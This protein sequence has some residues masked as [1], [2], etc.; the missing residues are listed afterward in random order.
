MI[1]FRLISWPY[2]RKH[3][4]RSLLTI[5]GIVIGHGKSVQAF[6]PGGGDQSFLIRARRPTEDAPGF[7][8]GGISNLAKQR[9]KLQH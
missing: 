7:R 6:P 4:L 9:Q 3:A 8:A 1:L 5:A 2:V